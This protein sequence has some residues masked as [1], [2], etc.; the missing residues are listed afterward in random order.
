MRAIYEISK[1]KSIVQGWSA[2]LPKAQLPCRSESER[3]KLSK[4][5][6]LRREHFDRI[7]AKQN[8]LNTVFAYSGFEGYPFSLLG[9]SIADPSKSSNQF[10]EL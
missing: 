10:H 2:N 4:L 5:Y 6:L 3:P 9:G 8:V 1:G 7:L